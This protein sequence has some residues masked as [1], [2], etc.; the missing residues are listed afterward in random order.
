MCSY[1]MSQIA[2]QVYSSF[3]NRVGGKGSLLIFTFFSQILKNEVVFYASFLFSD[4]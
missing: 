3:C 2:V 1:I 4:M